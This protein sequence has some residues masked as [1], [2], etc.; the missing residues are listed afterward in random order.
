M[1]DG[2]CVCLYVYECALLERGCMFCFAFPF[3]IFFLTYLQI[4]EIF[5]TCYNELK[6]W[7]RSAHESLRDLKDQ[8]N[9]TDCGMKM[10]SV[11]IPVML[12]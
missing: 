9:E 5:E 3:L 1:I 10:R 4:D 7:E 8:Q 6:D 12:L 11:N 2:S